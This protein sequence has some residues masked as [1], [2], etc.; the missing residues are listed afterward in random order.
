M[1][2]LSFIFDDAAHAMARHSD[3]LGVPPLPAVVYM[4]QVDV[5]N[6]YR[7]ALDHYFSLSLSESFLQNSSIG[8]P[9][10]K[11]AY[12][13][14]EDFGM[15]SFAIH[16]LL[17]YTSRLIHETECAALRTSERSSEMK[18]LSNRFTGPICEVRY[19]NKAIGISVHEDNHLSIA[20]VRTK[21]S[22]ERVVARSSHSE[23]TTYYL[24]VR[25]DAGREIEK[26]I[27]LEEY[28]RI[29]EIITAER[30]EI[31]DRSVLNDL[32]QR[33]HVEVRVL[34]EKNRIFQEACRNFYSSRKLVEPFDRLNESY[35][36]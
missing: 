36:I 30:I 11:W 5:I 28:Q 35:W 7:Y 3:H 21:P 14:N 4:M 31:R 33:G 24:V 13:T 10:Q 16:N 12:F 20:A 15:L 9:Y 1:L 2:N 18:D 25:D 32:R 17:R 19:R 27:P 29:T 6:H 23:P 34:V 26:P 22:T 8:T